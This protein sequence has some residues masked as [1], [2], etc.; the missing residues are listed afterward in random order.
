M[1]MPIEAKAGELRRAF[2]RARAAPI[3]SYAE[4][5]T[6]DLIALRIGQRPYAIRITE[7]S[8]LATNK[9]IAGIPSSI[10]QL[11]GL[12]AIRGSL[13][14]VYSL[15]ALLE[16]YEDTEKARWLALCGTEEYF[17][18]AFGEFEGHVRIPR[19]QLHSAER[20]GLASTH[21]THVARTA[22]EVRPV[23]SIPLIRETIQGRCRTGV[24]K[25]R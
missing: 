25:E 11:L 12:A 4:S 5:Q 7:I 15:G 21:V 22:D 16:S 10:S 13:V 18:L 2:D 1:A 14:P 19:D 23:I 9:K 6:E 20:G 24:S 8:G 17:G 3:S